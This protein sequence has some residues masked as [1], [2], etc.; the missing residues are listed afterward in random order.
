M[1]WCH[2]G[3]NRINLP[4]LTPINST[5]PAS[6]V[7]SVCV[8]IYYICKNYLTDLHK[9][10]VGGGSGSTNVLKH[11]LP[12]GVLAHNFQNVQSSIVALKIPAAC[13]F[14]KNSFFS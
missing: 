8:L 3:H 12:L 10:V 6:T 13:I 11:S 5:L 7:Y 2:E 9:N 1:T 14:N 4:P